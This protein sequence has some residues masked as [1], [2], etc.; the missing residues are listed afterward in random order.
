MTDAMTNKPTSDQPAPRYGWWRWAVLAVILI[1][2]A[3]AG[4]AWY[5][6]EIRAETG[7]ESMPVVMMTM[8]AGTLTGVWWLLLSPFRWRTRLIGAAV[9]VLALV[10]LANVI[11]IEGGTDGAVTAV[12][13]RWRWDPPR[14]AQLA[15]LAPVEKPAVTLTATSPDDYPGF[16]G[17]DRRG[18]ITNVRL[19]R[20]WEKQPPRQVWRQ[21]IGAGWSAF[22][23]VG[24]YAVTQE[25]RGPDELVTCYETATGKLLWSHADK[26]R[27]SETLGGDGPRATPTLIDGRVYALGATGILNCL[28]G[29]DG[30]VV[31]RRDTLVENNQENLE[32][33]KSCS[34][35]VTDGVVIVT[36]GKK[37]MTGG[38]S[39]IAYDQ[40]TGEP[41]WHAIDDKC[42]YGSPVLATLAGRKQVVQIFQ[43]CAAGIDPKDGKVLWKYDWPGD[44]AKCPDAMPLDGD[45][46]W[47]PSGYGFGN[48][49]LQVKAKGDL[50]AV[51]EIWKG[52]GLS[53]RFTNPVAK[54][55]YGYGLDEGVLACIDLATGE[56]KWKN[57]RYK[58]GQVLLVGG[59][60]LVQT[61]DGPVALAEA[62]PAGFKELTRFDALNGKTWN[63]PVVAGKY[64]LVRNSEEA[65]CY[66]LPLE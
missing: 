35:L 56:R 24:P 36:L 66:E 16:L 47:L 9:A 55:G 61:E 48:V 34:P 5:F 51:E 38:L 26:V 10:G 13:T 29:A 63:T 59:V 40:A 54:D 62:S 27:F 30:K 25:Q 32:W 22:A 19:A 31:W 12:R 58:H 14:D 39:I 15:P 33:A 28:E 37:A 21:P 60:L 42:G 57:G 6:K 1:G 50:Q 20:D 18:T 65:A 4:T 7:M 52:R 49:M 45:R 23:V 43:N 44:M 53:T 46:V 2:T 17:A 3:T 11:V 8:L 41:K 64:L